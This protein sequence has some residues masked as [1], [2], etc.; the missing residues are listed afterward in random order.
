LPSLE[1]VCFLKK[2][3]ETPVRNQAKNRSSCVMVKA[4]PT[5]TAN[6]STTSAIAEN[7]IFSS[8]TPIYEKI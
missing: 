8:S 3:T 4:H 2:L 6:V 5:E 1:H 7:E